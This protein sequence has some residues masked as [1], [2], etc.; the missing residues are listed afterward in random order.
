V[1]RGD[2]IERIDDLGKDRGLSVLVKYR[3]GGWEIA[4][5]DRVQDERK[6]DAGVVPGG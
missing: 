1:L 3:R 5:V 4:R 6:A 2:P